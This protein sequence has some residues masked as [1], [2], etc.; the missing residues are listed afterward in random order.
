L[1]ECMLRRREGERLPR[2]R[3]MRKPR[4]TLIV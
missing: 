1:A 3:L 2:E 4:C